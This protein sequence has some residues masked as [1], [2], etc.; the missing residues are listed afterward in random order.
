[1][2][3]S[4]ATAA[5]AVFVAK[6][7]ATALIVAIPLLGVWAGSSLARYE[8]GPLWVA[9]VAGLVAFPVAPLTWEAY[10]R[11]RRSRRPKARPPILTTWDR[12]IVRTFVINALL[13]GALAGWPTAT[14]N[15]LSTR[16][17]WFLEDNHGETAESV[18]TGLLSTADGLA[19]LYEAAHENQFADDAPSE[20]EDVRVGETIGGSWRRRCGGGAVLGGSGRWEPSRDGSERTGG[21]LP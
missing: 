10:A 11:W 15:A 14:F 12:L 18:R 1:M 4:R 19:F 8:D 16:G 6:S 21:A 20:D 2:K 3:A 7:I 17:D 5:T 13:V 9:L